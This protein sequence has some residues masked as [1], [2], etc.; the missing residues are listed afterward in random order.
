M[1]APFNGPGDA[2]GPAL[3]E[4]DHL[5]DYLGVTGLVDHAY[6]GSHAAVDVIVKAGTLVASRD[7]LRTRSVREQFL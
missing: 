7:D 4:Q 3:H 6:A 1:H 5:G 2:I